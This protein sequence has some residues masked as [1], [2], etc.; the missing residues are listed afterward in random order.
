MFSSKEILY[1][2]NK[3]RS[4][5]NIAITNNVGYKSSGPF[6]HIKNSAIRDTLTTSNIRFS[7]NLISQQQQHQKK[8]TR[9]YSTIDRVVKGKVEMNFRKA[10]Q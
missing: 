1:T 7:G 6:H 8:S 3:A 5:S 4:N 10:C 9:P 2:P